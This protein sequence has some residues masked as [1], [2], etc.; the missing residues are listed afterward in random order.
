MVELSGR[1]LYSPPHARVQDVGAGT[2]SSRPRMVWL[3]LVYH[4]FSLGVTAS[5]KAAEASGMFALPPVYLR[6]A[7]GKRFSLEF[8]LSAAL[9]VAWLVQLYRLKRS[10]VYAVT[11]LIAYRAVLF[12]WN[13]RANMHL[14]P[15]ALFGKVVGLSLNIAI[16]AYAW[17][18]WR[19]SV[20]E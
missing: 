13:W 20:L 2:E 14:P 19:K 1:N 18:L 11:I 6:L 15:P 7:G 3:I 4:A 17:S 10:A 8:G 16:C 12:T 5:L 9:L